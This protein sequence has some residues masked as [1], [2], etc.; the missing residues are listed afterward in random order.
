MKEKTKKSISGDG[1]NYLYSG[2]FLKC[3]QKEL[4]QMDQRTRKPMKM[5]KALNP[6]DDVDRLIESRKEEG[7]GRG[8][9]IKKAKEN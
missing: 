1:R 3:T 8:N 6:R 2:P 7:R 9:Y 5:R 4:K